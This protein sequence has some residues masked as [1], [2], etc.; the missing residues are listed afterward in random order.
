MQ[1]FKIKINNYFIYLF[2]IIIAFVTIFFAINLT[3]KIYQYVNNLRN[4]IEYLDTVN[5][6]IANQVAFLENKIIE[7]SQTKSIV[8][9]EIFPQTEFLELEYKEISLNNFIKDNSRINENVEYFKRDGKKVLSFYVE[10]TDNHIILI[11][12]SGNANYLKF[13]NLSEFKL[14]PN[15]LPKNINVTD[16]L[17]VGSK[18]Y[19]AFSKNNKD[20]GNFH[21]YN[22]ELNLDELIFEKLFFYDPLNGQKCLYNAGGRIEYNKE[23]HSLY[24]S[25]YDYDLKNINLPNQDNFGKDYKFAVIS[26]LNIN[27]NSVKVISRGH[28]N[29]QGLL[30]TKDNFILST[31]HGPRGGDE[32]NNIIEGKNYGWP[33][34]SY[35]ELYKGGYKESEAHSFK[36]NHKK[37]NYEDPVFSFV[38]SIGISQII[39]LE[40]NFS[41]KWQNNFLISS[42]RGQSIYRIK[43]DDTYNK[44]LFIEKIRIGN[45]I[46]DINYNKKNKKILLAL[47]NNSGA[48]GIIDNKNN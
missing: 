28:R 14:L 42:L 40:N 20:C 5:A 36:K 17:L 27:N 34:A 23:K 35:G 7:V 48:L 37:Y 8:N 45:R 10:S 47:E 33:D 13:L 41:K 19:V 6:E 39:D 38:P 12:K 21:V 43:F 46:R 22:A 16:T 9:E 30:M 11:D 31:E 29:P 18:L 44:V 3:T 25:S 1:I 26:E 4:H 24:F 32:I 15:N 2:L